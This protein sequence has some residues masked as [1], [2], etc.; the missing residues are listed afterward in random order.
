MLP[1]DLSVS[2]NQ[3]Y[4]SAIV[5]ALVDAALIPQ[6][7]WRIKPARFWELRWTLVGIG[8]AALVQGGWRRLTGIRS[9]RHETDDA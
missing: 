9:I 5:I 3:F 2:S 4:W 7:V 6:L 8:L 1:E